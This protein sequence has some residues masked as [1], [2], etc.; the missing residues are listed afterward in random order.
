MAFNRW[1]Q[2]QLP[3]DNLYHH[4][5]LTIRSRFFVCLCRSRLSF[6][7]NKTPMELNPHFQIVQEECDKKKKVRLDSAIVWHL[8]TSQ[9]ITAFKLTYK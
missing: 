5:A 3:P 6:R 7:P 9:Q 2:L 1:I 8:Q 4:Q